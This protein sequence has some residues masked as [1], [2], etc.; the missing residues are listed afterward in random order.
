MKSNKAQLTIIIDEIQTLIDPERG[1]ILDGLISRLKTQF[2]SQF[3]Y[4]SATLGEPEF[5]SKRLDCELIKYDN[6]PVPVERHLLLCLNENQKQKYISKLVRA[7]FSTKSVYGFKGQTIVFTNT[8]KKCESI[9]LYLQNKG[10]KVSAYHSGL[11][12]EER[13]TIEENFL[14][15]RIMG[16]VATAALA[17][18]VDLPAS[19]VIFESLAMGINWLSVAEFEQMIGR[20]GRLKKHEKGLAYILVEPGK[21]YSPKMKITEENTAIKLLNGKIK[22]YE[23]IPD[24][25]K[26]Q[27]EILAFIAMFNEWISKEI[28]FEFYDNL[29][30]NRFDLEEILRKLISFNFLLLVFP[31]KWV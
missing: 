5:L 15:Q 31:I 10:L 2:N 4:L 18:G 3:L 1:F 29:I 23:L 11:T 28:I 19:Q 14:S 16:V 12:N 8:R 26:S 20:S 30:N 13:K 27:T 21:I 7:A 17:A 6:R 22:D 25:N 9:S 24:E